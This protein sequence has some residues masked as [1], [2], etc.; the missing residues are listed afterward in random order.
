MPTCGKPQGTCNVPAPRGDVPEGSAGVAHLTPDSGG[1]PGAARC[2][3]PYQTLPTKR[4]I[5]GF[6][7]TAPT[8]HHTGK[9]KPRFYCRVSVE[10]YRKE[11]DGSG[12]TLDTVF[13]GLVAFTSIP[14]SLV[15][16]FATERTR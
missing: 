5:H 11:V 13:C 2:Q 3:E 16:V 8:I 4:S 7:A 10:Q 6:I 14:C 1:H 15:A 9:G 12:T